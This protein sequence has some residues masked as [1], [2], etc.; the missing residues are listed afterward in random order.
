MI[1]TV[2]TPS[3]CSRTR[4]LPRDEPSEESLLLQQSFS[5][6][7]LPE[8][9]ICHLLC[10]V[11]LCLIAQFCLTLCNPVDCSP[12]GSLVHGDCSGKNTEVG[13]LSLLQG[14]PGPRNQTGGFLHCR[15]IHYQLSYQG[16]PSNQGSYV[17]G[18]GK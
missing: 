4:S 17:L 11:L 3:V 14:S 5:S 10:A 18:P 2:F 8:R 1:V 6:F 7:M 15:Q 12:P 9:V 16:T 13:S